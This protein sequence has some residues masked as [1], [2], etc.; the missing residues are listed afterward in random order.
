MLHFHL[1]R[2]Q[3]HNMTKYSTNQCML[4]QKP[5]ACQGSE[6]IYLTRTLLLHPVWS[7]ALGS[8]HLPQLWWHKVQAQTG[9]EK[10]LLNFSVVFLFRWQTQ[11]KLLICHFSTLHSPPN[12]VFPDLSHVYLTKGFGL[13]Q[14]NPEQFKWFFNFH[15]LTLELNNLFQQIISGIHMLLNA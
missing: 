10:H 14:C 4:A 9:L 15:S 12:H 5:H 6:G 2:D 13:L 7:Q 1:L 3:T 11:Q 8:Q